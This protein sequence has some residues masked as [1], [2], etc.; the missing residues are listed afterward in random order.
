MK[1]VDG[2]GGNLASGPENVKWSGL[3]YPGAVSWC[4]LPLPL[5]LT[6]CISSTEIVP[7]PSSSYFMNRLPPRAN[8]Q[9]LK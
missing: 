5:I 4:L 6:S 9:P 8:I 1:G 2:R 7:D 3:Q